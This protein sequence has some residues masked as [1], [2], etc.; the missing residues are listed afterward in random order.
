[1]TSLQSYEPPQE[2][3]QTLAEIFEIDDTG[4]LTLFRQLKVINHVLHRLFDDY[5]K[6]DSKL[7]HA[8]MR[9]LIRLETDARQGN[10]AGLLP[11][12]L[13]QWLGVSRNTVS[14]LLNGLE[15]QN[16]IERELH[17]TDRRQILIRITDEGRDLIQT[18]APKIGTFITTLFTVLDASEQELLSALLEKLLSGMIQYAQ[19]LDMKI[20][21]PALP[22]D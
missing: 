22:A 16:L 7:S 14:S 18:H 5:Q 21:D 8:R 3:E 6:D 9:L 15:K 4:A 11:S 10:T 19:N 1:M 17:P 2:I 13:S 20:S 12:E